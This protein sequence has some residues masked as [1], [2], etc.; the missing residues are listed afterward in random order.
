MEAGALHAGV[1]HPGLPHGVVPPLKV[2]LRCEGRRREVK[3]GTKTAQHSVFQ[4]LS[5]IAKI[6]YLAMPPQMGIISLPLVI[7]TD[8]RQFSDHTIDYSIDYIR[9]TQPRVETARFRVMI[10]LTS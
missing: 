6:L 7:R 9:I 5:K 3:R 8:L 2:T 4:S 10:P 1:V